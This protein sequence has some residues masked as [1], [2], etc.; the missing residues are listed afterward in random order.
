MDTVL[1]NPLEAY[2]TR[3]KELHGGNTEKFFA[4][5]VERS[6]VDIEKNRKTV[7]QRSE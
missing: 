3:L 2:E 5:L 1:Y 6:G 7:R 4:E